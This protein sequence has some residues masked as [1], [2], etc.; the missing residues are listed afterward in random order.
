[1]LIEKYCNECVSCGRKK[2]GTRQILNNDSL[3]ILNHAC[4]LFH[5]LL[6]CVNCVI[7][8]TSGRCNR[9]PNLLCCIL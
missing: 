1:M 3:F 6:I 4:S 9:Q 5:S 2:L 8:Y 7:T